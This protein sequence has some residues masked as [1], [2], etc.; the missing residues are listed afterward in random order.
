VNPTRNRSTIIYVLLFAAIII[1]VVY[2]FNQNAS[3][4]AP[5][6]INELAAD[7]QRGEVNRII[8]NEDR[9]TVIYGEGEA[10]LKRPPPKKRTPL[11]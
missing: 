10:P 5:L 1:L 2:N 9:L 4:Q 6:T 7:I 8:A 3:S 11:W